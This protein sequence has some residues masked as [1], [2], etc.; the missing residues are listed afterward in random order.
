MSVLE[1][2]CNRA[3]WMRSRFEPQE[4]I[5][6][7]TWASISHALSAR[8]CFRLH[9]AALYHQFL[10]ITRFIAA[11]CWIKLPLEVEWSIVAQSINKTATMN[12]DS[13]SNYFAKAASRGSEVISANLISLE[14]KTHNFPLFTSNSNQRNPF[15]ETTRPGI[16]TSQFLCLI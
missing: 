3:A 9:K 15:C 5:D 13:D 1:P 6:V 14:M 10:S 2:P 4:L 8:C 12:S 11:I 7:Q 16:T